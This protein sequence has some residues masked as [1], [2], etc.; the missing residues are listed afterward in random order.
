[1]FQ[2]FSIASVVD[3]EKVNVFWVVRGTF[4]HRKFSLQL[5]KIFR[6][7][8]KILQ[9]WNVKNALIP[10]ELVFPKELKTNSWN[11]NLSFFEIPFSVDGNKA[12]V[13]CFHFNFWNTDSAIDICNIFLLISGEHKFKNTVSIVVLN[14]Q[15]KLFTTKISSME[16]CFYHNKL[17]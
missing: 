5:I 11:E 8:S 4:N 16:A 13:I 17:L 15:Y 10:K 9:Y 1:M 6:F 2:T 3:L 14:R 12:C 7:P